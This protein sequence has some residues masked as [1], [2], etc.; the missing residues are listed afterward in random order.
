MDRKVLAIDEL[1][2]SEDLRDYFRAAAEGPYQPQYQ[3]AGC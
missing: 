2:N 1:R 3:T